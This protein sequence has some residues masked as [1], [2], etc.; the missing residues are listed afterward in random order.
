MTPKPDRPGRCRYCGC[1]YTRPCPAPCGWADANQTLCTECVDVDMDFH[2]AAR[3]NKA[4]RRPNHFYQF[5]KAF[6]RGWTVGV[7]DV[8][9]QVDGLD[10][11]FKDPGSGRWWNF[12]F[13]RGKDRLA[14]RQAFRKPAPRRKHSSGIRLPGNRK[15]AR[16]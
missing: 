14:A 6:F 13:L 10:N 8:D 12:G 2:E 9:R 4:S 15:A 1:T 3:E 5:R 11:P 7:G 16:A